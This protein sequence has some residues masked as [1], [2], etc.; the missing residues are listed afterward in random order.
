MLE[1][2]IPPAILQSDNGS[3]FT[4]QVLWLPLTMVHGKPRHPQSQGSVETA[5]SYNSYIKD[6]LHVVAWM[7]DNNTQDWTVGLK[8]VQQQKNSAYHA[9]IGIAT[10]F[11][12]SVLTD[13][14]NANSKSKSKI[15]IGF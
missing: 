1:I 4:A 5:N 6:K 2:T 10:D 15:K 13:F 7:T 3:E 11:Q 12:K 14:I 9:G 8:F